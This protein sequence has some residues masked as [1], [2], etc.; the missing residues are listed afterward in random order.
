MVSQSAPAKAAWFA[1]QH[2]RDRVAALLSPKDVLNHHLT[3]ELATDSWTSKGLVNV[4]T[5]LPATTILAAAGWS[6][7][8]IATVLRP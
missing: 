8:I 6:D 3:G 5:S 2:E 7:D 4:R 1:G